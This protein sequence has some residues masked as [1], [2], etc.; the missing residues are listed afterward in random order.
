MEQTETDDMLAAIREKMSDYEDIIEEQSQLI[1]KLD[2]R[3]HDYRPA[4][5]NAFLAALVV[6]M[7]G[8]A[9]GVNM[10]PK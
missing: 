9:L 4:V 2:P 1:A 3:T 8:V 10:C 5:I 7:W 6:Y